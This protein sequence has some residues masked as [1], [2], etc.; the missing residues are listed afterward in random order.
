MP[1]GVKKSGARRIF[2]LP[3]TGSIVM[4]PVMTMQPLQQRLAQIKTELLHLGPIHP[5]SISEQYNVCGTPGCRCK[6]AKNP[7]KHGPYGQLSY[8]WRGKGATRFV[9]P[10]RLALL[11][12]KIARYRQFRA[13]TDEWVDLAIRLEQMER[14]AARRAP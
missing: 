4:M 6:D 9:R 3:M 11:R 12:E 2:L 5:G 14:D 10:E 8:T 7:R 1:S 13:L